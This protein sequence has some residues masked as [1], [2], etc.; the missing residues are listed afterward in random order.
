MRRYVRM[1]EA[2]SIKGMAVTTTA[3]PTM[4]SVLHEN[5]TNSFTDSLA[6]LSQQINHGIFRK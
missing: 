2:P 5:V 3:I 6:I 4:I 1:Q